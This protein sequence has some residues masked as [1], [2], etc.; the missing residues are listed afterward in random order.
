VCVADTNPCTVD[1]CDPHF[2]C[3]PPAEL[4][5]LDG[6]GAPDAGGTPVAC[7]DG[8]LCTDPDQCRV[9]R[10]VGDLSA[11]AAACNLG[12]GNLCNGAESCNPLSGACEATEINCDD[13]NVCTD[14]TCDPLAQTLVTAC[15]HTNNTLGCDDTNACTDVDACVGGTCVGTLSA[16]A[17][18]CNAGD[19]DLCTGIEQC[20][21]TTGACD[22][23]PLVCDDANPCTSEV[24][25]PLNGC[26]YTMLTGPCDDGNA[27]T[28]A[29]ECVNGACLAAPTPTALGCSDGDACNGLETCD[30]AGGTCLPGTTPFCDDGDVCTTDACDPLTGCTNLGISGLEGALCEIDAILDQLAGPPTGAFRGPNLRRRLTRLARRARVKVEFATRAANPKA[31]TLLKGADKKLQVFTR[32]AE[33]GSGADRMSTDLM[34]RLTDRARTARAIIQ[35][36]RANLR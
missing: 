8:N 29:G 35:A 33:N 34:H 4:A 30:P 27:C 12:D 28:G 26:Q 17:A 18:T 31:L 7:D 11:A 32:K 36:V 10:C 14:D 1:G 16:A 22:F 20:N 23:T 9:R 15:V 6:D 24:C 3:N 21:T 19:G 2:L 13:G 25:D 5:D